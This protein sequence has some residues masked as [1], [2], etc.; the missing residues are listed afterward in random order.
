MYKNILSYLMMGTLLI[1]LMGCSGNEEKNADAGNGESSVKEQTL[2]VWSFTDDLK[3]PIKDFEDKYGC[4]VKLTIIPYADYKIKIMPVLGSGVGA[5]DVFTAEAKFIKE[6]AE[7]GFYQNLSEPPFNAGDFK[8]DYVPYVFKLGEDSKGDV[9][10]LS[11]QMT[12]GGIFYRRSIAKEVFGTDEPQKIGELLSTMDNV[13]ETA[14][15]LK[16][17]G[18][19]LFPSYNAL[20]YFANPDQTPWV[21]KDERLMLTDSRLHFFKYAKDIRDDGY[22]AEVAV[23][24]PVWF[25]GMYGPIPDGDTGKE[26]TIFAYTLPTWGLPYTLKTSTPNS[27]GK[28]PTWGDWAVTSGPSSYFRGG[29]WLG[30]YSKSK[31]KDLAWKFI[32]FMTHDEEYLTKYISETGDVPSLISLQEQFEDNYSESFLGGQNNMKFFI[33]EGK[34]INPDRITKYDQEIDTL[35]NAAVIDYVDG[36]RTYDE[37]V[38]GFKDGVKSAFPEINVK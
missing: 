32:E 27:D 16:E 9:R 30:I 2:T 28:N 37:A 24:S 15:V 35:Y 33:D 13:F 3:K 10:A 34:N 25:A 18:Y 38:Q 17:N 23:E 6:F 26:T 14:E 19:K 22:T 21:N 29:T 36:N 20:S 4:K 1:L 11:W 12:P 5:P 8:N 7:L 31:N